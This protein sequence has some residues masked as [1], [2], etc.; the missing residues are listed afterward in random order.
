MNFRLDDPEDRSKGV[1]TAQEIWALMKKVDR[2]NTRMAFEVSRSHGDGERCVHPGSVYGNLKAALRAVLL[3]LGV[4]S[5]DMESAWQYLLETDSVR[6]VVEL[7]G[8][9]E[10][11]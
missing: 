5:R 6:D 9:D 11:R 3:S 1:D 8:V 10:S 4:D 7:F 2:H